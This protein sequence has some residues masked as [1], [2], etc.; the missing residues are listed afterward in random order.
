MRRPDQRRRAGNLVALASIAAATLL[1]APAQASAQSGTPD[2]RARRLEITP[3]AAY[4]FGGGL[5]VDGGRLEIPGAFTWG[6]MIDLR[7]RPDAQAEFLYS[8]QE[9]D[10]E[11]H[12]DSLAR[13]VALGGLAVHYFQ[14]GGTV[15]LRPGP[16]RPYAV[17]TLGVTW[18]DPS[19][20]LDGEA[21]F[22][23]GL[24]AGLRAGVNERVAARLEGRWWINVF[25]S[26]GSV[27]CGPAGC[28]IQASGSV[29]SQG[30][31]S[32]GLGIAF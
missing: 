25:D 27:F 14:L 3:F 10:L 23:G 7:V 28:V 32:G 16:V 29:V 1:L 5:N 19:E 18:F 11:F 20:D 4:Q 13:P 26:S 15:D 21:R 30:V 17:A 8:R 9:T 22:S 31:V 2:A 6:A 12:P 24:G